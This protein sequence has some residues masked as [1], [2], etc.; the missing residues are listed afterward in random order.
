MRGRVPGLERRYPLWRPWVAVMLVALATAPAE[1]QDMCLACHSNHDFMVS[2]R[3]DAQVDLL[4][5][6]ANQIVP[7]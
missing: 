3:G 2:V 6:W 4:R 7:I 1:A 5:A